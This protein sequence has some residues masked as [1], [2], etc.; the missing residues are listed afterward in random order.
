M[1]KMGLTVRGDPPR[2]IDITHREWGEP[3]DGVVLSIR[4]IPREDPEQ[5]V[6][7]SA[8]MKNGGGKEIP[9]TIPG[10]LYFFEMEIEAQA[11]PYGRSLL[12]PKHKQEP[13]KILL[14]PGAATETDL[15]VGSIFDLR[16]GQDY[17]LRVS[18]RL[19]DDRVL[20]SNELSI[21]P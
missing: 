12:R 2:S 1:A 3:V 5:L 8:V 10:W 18:C 19:P 4:G 17:K 7:V 11:T 6:S 15:P 9:L 13:L 14:G 20:R 16:R 21:K